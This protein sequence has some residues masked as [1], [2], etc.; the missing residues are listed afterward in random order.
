[1]LEGIKD[2]ENGVKKD[3]GKYFFGMDFEER[4]QYIKDNPVEEEYQSEKMSI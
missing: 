2:I 3:R 4:I 1:V